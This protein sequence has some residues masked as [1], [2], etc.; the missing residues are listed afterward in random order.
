MIQ[1][2]R[3][4]PANRNLGPY[5][6]AYERTTTILVVEDDFAVAELLRS[7]INSSR[8]WGAVVV[9]DPAGALDVMQ[10]VPVDVLVLDVNLPGMSGPQLLERLRD[11]PHWRNQQAIFMSA[12]G[13]HPDVE[14]ALR[15]GVA[16][17]F[18]A[19]PFDLDELIDAIDIAARSAGS[20]RHAQ[21]EPPRGTWRAA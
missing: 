7:A 13:P 2:T 11:T 19:K 1:D 12:A 18:I 17:R 8:G 20:R 5:G 6:D 10:H 16:T 21:Q 4:M 15:S 14:R 3:H 9:R